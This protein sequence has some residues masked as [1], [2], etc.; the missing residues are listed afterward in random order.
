[1]TDFITVCMRCGHALKQNDI[2]LA[3]RGEMI[4]FVG[5]TFQEGI[6]CCFCSECRAAFWQ[7]AEG[8]ITAALARMR[9]A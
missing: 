8:G 1:M 4:D 7:Y 6:D 9:E 3:I 2:A 5:R